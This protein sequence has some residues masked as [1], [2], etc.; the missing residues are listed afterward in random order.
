M[1]L[2]I[3]GE[4]GHAALGQIAADMV[5]APGVLTETMDQ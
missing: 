1:P 4:D 5:V 2:M 3:V